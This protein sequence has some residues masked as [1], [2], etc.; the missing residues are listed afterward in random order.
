[1][2]K[3]LF[4]LATAILGSA[5]A[6]ANH[7]WDYK[8]NG[9]DWVAKT[10]K[11]LKLTGSAQNECGGSNQSPIDLKMDWR[12][13][14]AK[15]DNF[16]KLY[17]NQVESRKN[18]PDIKVEW[19]GHTSQTAINKAGQ[20]LQKFESQH[21]KDYYGANLRYT[22]AQ[23]HFHHGSEHTIEGVRQDLEMH[24]VHLADGAV[25]NGFFASAVG[26]FFS[27]DSPSREFSAEEVAVVDKFFDGL[28]WDNNKTS[29]V[30][31]VSYGDFMMMV[32][33]DKRWTYKGSVTTPPCA[34]NVYWNI[35]TTVY[36]IKQKNLDQFKFLLKNNPK[37]NILEG[38]NYRVIQALTDEHNPT[39]VMNA[40]RGGGPLFVV[41]FIVFFLCTLLSCG[42]IWQ[43]T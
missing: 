11:E 20:D 15:E 27:V 13:V 4:T 16:Q 36:P 5:S 12:K 21:G 24:T 19:N 6:A 7:P 8:L 33:T 38:G 26:V 32:D 18:K 28:N 43:M 23:F 29:I 30:S 22:G 3:T 39:I 25:Q 35:L 31:E 40:P 37:Y 17:T 2:K 42:R 41:L 14:P 34:Q 9:S 10:A 1:M